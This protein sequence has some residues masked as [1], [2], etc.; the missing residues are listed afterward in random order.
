MGV[1]PSL[2]RVCVAML[3][4]SVEPDANSAKAPEIDPDIS[5]GLAFVSA[6]TQ[7]SLPL[8]PPPQTPAAAAAP[9]AASQRETI[10]K[11]E[12]IDSVFCLISSVVSLQT[13]AAAL[14]DC[15]LVPALLSTLELPTAPSPNDNVLEAKIK[16]LR[17][18]IVAQA[19]QIIEA[20]ILNHQ[21]ALTA[22]N[23]LNGSELLVNRLNKEMQATIT[24][25]GVAPLPPPPPPAA[26]DPNAD[27]EDDLPA[28]VLDGAPS[29][30]TAATDDAPMEVDP[31]ASLS[32]QVSAS[33]KQSWSGIITSTSGRTEE[34]GERATNP[35]RAMLGRQYLL[36]HTRPP[37]TSPLARSP[38][39]SLRPSGCCCTPS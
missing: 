7:P 30:P 5:L 34:A 4:D 23:D 17:T 3:N 6:T 26:P 25:S 19:V 16:G 21:T 29:T 27:S 31:P 12:W 33:A 11:L 28:M 32:Q 18:Y 37:L 36:S 13:G 9:N 38:A 39:R 24:R 20:C 10:Q 22:F 14:T 35:M 1:L 15:G 8:P 2:V